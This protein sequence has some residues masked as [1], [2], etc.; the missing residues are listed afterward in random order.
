MHNLCYPTFKKI[1]DPFISRNKWAMK[2]Y[3]LHFIALVDLSNFVFFFNLLFLLIQT[4]L[5][6]F[7]NE[8]FRSLI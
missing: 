6:H 5:T 7:T 8:L 1:L 2:H 4:F 3:R